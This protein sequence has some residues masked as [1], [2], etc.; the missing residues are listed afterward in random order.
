M[1]YKIG[2]T[3]DRSHRNHDHQMVN[4]PKEITIIPQSHTRA[5][6]Q[7]VMIKPQNADFAL[8][9]VKTSRWPPNVTSGAVF[10]LK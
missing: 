6:P 4:K 3:K 5:N 1:Y 10:E 2:D 8:P 9:A 7:T